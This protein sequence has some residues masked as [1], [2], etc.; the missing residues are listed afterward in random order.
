MQGVGKFYTIKSCEDFII[1]R[2]EPVYAFLSFYIIKMKFLKIG[3]F[4]KTIRIFLMGVSGYIV[5]YKVYNFKIY[6][7][8]VN[9]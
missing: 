6:D 8:K 3:Q 1:L 9:V 4:D 2:Q 5:D 7:N